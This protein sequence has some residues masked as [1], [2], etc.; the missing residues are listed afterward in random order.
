MLSA[1]LQTE[2]LPLCTELRSCLGKSLEE[3]STAEPVIWLMV[4]KH[5]DSSDY[6]HMTLGLGNPS[7]ACT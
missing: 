2:K 1:L 4:P 5:S 3:E 7:S 6:F